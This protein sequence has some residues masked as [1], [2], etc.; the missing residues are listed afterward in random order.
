MSQKRCDSPSLLSI[1]Y[2]HRHLRDLYLL[3]FPFHP[4]VSVAEYHQVNKSLLSNLPELYPRLNVW[5]VLTERQWPTESLKSKQ[6]ICAGGVNKDEESFRLRLGEF[7]C[8][9]PG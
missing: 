2:D 8:K 6:I 9:H 4:Y 5:V 3:R 7:R 1:I